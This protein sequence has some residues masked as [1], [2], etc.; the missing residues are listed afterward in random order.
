VTLERQLPHVGQQ[1]NFTSVVFIEGKAVCVDT[2]M[3]MQMPYE[4]IAGDRQD[5][6]PRG[7]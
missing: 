6:T 4:A 3:A 1:F 5:R 7:I 2:V